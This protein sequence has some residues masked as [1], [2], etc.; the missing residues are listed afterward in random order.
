MSIQRRD[1]SFA[2]RFELGVNVRRANTEFLGRP[3][4][5]PAELD[6]PAAAW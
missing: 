4:A 6:A 2:T 1:G 3:L 5:L